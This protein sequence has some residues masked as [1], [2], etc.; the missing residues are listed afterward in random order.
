MVDGLTVLRRVRAAKPEQP[1]LL[2]TALCDL[3][4]RV[5]GLNA[6]SSV[7]VAP[8]GGHLYVTGEYD[9][10]R[11][12]QLADTLRAMLVAFTMPA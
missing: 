12:S 8:D 5:D 9:E 3:E 1:I 11:A 4:H 6:A 7:I 2:L 10:A